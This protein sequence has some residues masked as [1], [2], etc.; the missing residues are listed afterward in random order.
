MNKKIAKLL[1]ILILTLSIIGFTILIIGRNNIGVDSDLGVK[2]SEKEFNIVLNNKKTRFT[3]K[4][5]EKD[6]I[7]KNY[8]LIGNIFKTKRIE[9]SGFESEIDLCKKP[10]L[11]MRE[12]EVIC[13][14]GDVGVHSQNIVIIDS[15]YSIIR[16]QEEKNILK[17]IIS[18]LPNYYI[19]DYNNDGNDDLIVYNRDY[20]KNPINNLIIKYY[21]GD[22]GYFVFDKEDHI[23]VK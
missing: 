4:Y 7:N 15:N 8:I 13:L 9:L 16:F 5:Y 3:I 17:N 12:K 14:A 21:R 2:K 22:S 18:D 19:Q 11:S 10:V 6:G 23:A 20:D 1:L